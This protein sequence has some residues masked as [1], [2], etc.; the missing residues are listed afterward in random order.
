M[1]DNKDGTYG[2]TYNPE[3]PG[4]YKVDVILRGA[5][6]LFYD[7]ISGS[8]VVVDAAGTT[9]SLPFFPFLSLSNYLLCSGN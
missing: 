6:P 4:R 7:H 8:P 2:V 9:L 1:V 5:N 3:E